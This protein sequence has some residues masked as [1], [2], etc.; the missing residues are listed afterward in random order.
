MLVF[1]TVED[2][3]EEVDS[4]RRAEIIRGYPLER[5]IVKT[6]D[7]V[8]EAYENLGLRSPV[9]LRV[10]LGDVLGSRLAKATASH[11][12]GFDRPL[13]TTE[14]LGIIQMIKPLGRSLRPILDSL[15]RAAGWPDGSPSYGRG[16]WEGYLNPYPYQ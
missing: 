3:L 15:W 5:L 13:V 14:V 8:S 1:R 9:F 11:S 12:K 6:L 2:E 16:E 7:A 10:E 4:E